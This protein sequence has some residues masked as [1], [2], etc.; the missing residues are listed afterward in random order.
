MRL[1]TLVMGMAVLVMAGISLA[2]YRNQNPT[3]DPEQYFHSPQRLGLMT[4]RGLLDPNRMHM[5]HYVSMGYMNGAGVSASR[6]LY[7]NTIDYQISRPLSVT[8]H[9]GY[10]FQPNGPAEWNPANYG[11]QFV[12]GAD[13]NWRPTNNTALRLSF[14]RGLLPDTYSSPYGWDSYGYRSIF[15]RP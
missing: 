2:Q 10:Q 7:M 13:L 14:Y 1:R 11:N 8:T 5:S 12:G 15:D 4:F 3:G 9:L 6:G